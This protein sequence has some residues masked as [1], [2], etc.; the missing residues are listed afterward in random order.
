MLFR[1]TCRR[2]RKFPW[3]VPAWW[4]IVQR[5][6]RALFTVLFVKIV[7]CRTS[8]H[9]HLSNALW[10]S[11]FTNFFLARVGPVF[12]PRRTFT[13]FFLTLFGPVFFK[14]LSNARWIS[15]VPR[16]TFYFFLTRF[17]PVFS[18]HLSN[19]RWTSVCS[20]QNVTNF[21][22]T[23]FGPVFVPHRTLHTSF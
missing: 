21:F 18:K 14:L 9:K 16:R 22:L 17:R 4:M 5:C 20:T 11:V 12:V 15:V 2:F 7:H 13:N 1:N 3:S 19:A 6:C 23:R 10:T 8:G